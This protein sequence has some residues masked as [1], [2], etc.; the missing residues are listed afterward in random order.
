MV[1]S[2]SMTKSLSV[3][4]L[5]DAAGHPVMVVKA[6]CSEKRWRGSQFPEGNHQDVFARAL[7]VSFADDD[8]QKLLVVANV[9]VEGV[10]KSVG[11]SLV[12]ADS[13]ATAC[14]K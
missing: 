14:Q 11:Y 5:E 12:A 6:Y 7:Q 10:E 13:L 3:K 9:E 1:I 4:A 2:D 8:S